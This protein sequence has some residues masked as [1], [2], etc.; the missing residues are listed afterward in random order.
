MA[1]SLATVESMAPDQAS[2]TAA[3]KLSQPNKWLSLSREGDLWW[4]ECQGS[5]ANPY[6]AVVD[7]ALVGYKCTCP[8]RKFPCKHS[9][10]LMWMVVQQPQSFAVGTTPQWVG[11]WLGRRRTTSSQ[12]AEPTATP[13][14]SA[15]NIGLAASS[16]APEVV[17][18]ATQARRDAAAR[19][20]QASN[21]AMIADGLDDLEHWIS[22]QL[23]MGLVSFA[24]AAPQ[25]CRRIAA[26][27][28]DNKA[29][30][31]ASR[32]DEM[33]SRLLGVP[34]GERPDAVIRELGRLVLLSKA[35]RADP[36]N[37]AASRE[38]GTPGR[39]DDVL[40]DPEA[41]RATGRWEVVGEQIQ[42]RRDGLVSHATW[43]LGLSLETPDRP[44]TDQPPFALLL[45]FYPASA[46]R[47]EV[48]FTVGTQYSATMVYYPGSVPLRAIALDLT[49]ADDLTPWPVIADADP[50]LQ[51]LPYLDATPWQ[52]EFPLL[53]PNG[54]IGVVHDGKQPDRRW[55]ISQSGDGLPLSPKASNNAAVLGLQLRQ[56]FGVWDGFRLNILSAETPLGQVVL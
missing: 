3:S 45:D 6:R 43:F 2:L 48:S 21:Q 22:D 29:S 53:L 19:K 13:Q 50:L 10:A 38:I 1:L 31:L 5:G 16:A 23:A 24:E 54:R 49:P 28:V 9:L 56:A 14:Q 18:E 27:L 25:H 34:A 8:S 40:A 12:K 39:R 37:P 11:D 52:L 30:G 4:G 33:P 36:A 55:W 41:R 44:V 47:R 42:T 7:T 20:R 46:G 17:D 35:W 32:I 26:R 15:K 51:T